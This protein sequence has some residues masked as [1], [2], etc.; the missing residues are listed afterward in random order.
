MKPHASVDEAIAALA[1]GTMVIVVDDQN[2]E[3]EGDLVMA[4]SLVTPEA[5]NF[6]TRFGRGLI[7]V[8]MTPERLAELNL[9]AMTPAPEDSM[10]T[11]FSVSVDAREGVTTGI[12]AFDRAR[13]IQ[14][15]ASPAA[16]ADDL[17]RP[18]HIFPLRAKPG[19]VLRRPGHTEASLDLMRLA[20]LA[21]VA[22]ICE[23]L[24]EDGTMARRPDLAKFAA[25]HRLPLITVADLIRYR[26]ARE[27]LAEREGEARLPTPH[28]VFRVVAYTERFSG[29]THLALVLGRPEKG[30][31]FLTR[32]HSECLTGD[33]FGSLRCDCGPQLQAA[34][35]QIGAAG[36][37]CLVYL[38]QEGR[39]IGLANK[40]KAYALQDQGLDTIA[41]NLALGF[42]PDLRDYGVAAQ[43]LLDLGVDTVRLI[44][45]N[46][47]K[48]EGLSEY[49][50]AIAERAPLEIPPNPE[51]AKYLETKRDQMGHWLTLADAS[52][53]EDQL[54]PNI[55][56][57]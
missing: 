21:P 52:S 16:T 44:T 23:I 7:C 49:G 29:L 37:G 34:L 15:L 39:G 19:G 46:P 3:N 28:G 10:R 6:M 42:P 50:I 1:A 31:P 48:V 17:V 20:G 53:K 55:K 26:L 33:V 47:G 54:W 14:T 22:V 51:N 11:D 36:E 9:P 43:I 24:N 13:T 57:F 40:I 41:A 38:R 2:R 27:T 5:V 56:G 12:S 30:R 25:A 4:G 32:I 8:P 45:N 35:A 18:G